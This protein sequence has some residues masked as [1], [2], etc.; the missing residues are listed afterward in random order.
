VHV[1]SRFLDINIV[2]G[3]F[4]LG[5]LFLELIPT[6]TFIHL[7]FF[8]DLLL[9]LLYV[10]ELELLHLI[11]LARQTARHLFDLAVLLALQ[12]IHVQGELGENTLSLLCLLLL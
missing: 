7:F 11:Q 1:T 6:D 2:E 3:L 4:D 12:I 5:E 10:G 8:V 9:D